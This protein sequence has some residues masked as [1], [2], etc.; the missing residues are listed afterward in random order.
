M[1]Y[2]DLI[3]IGVAGAWPNYCLISDCLISSSCFGLFI[4]CNCKSG[5]LFRLCDASPRIAT[6]GK[7][8]GRNF[9]LMA[10]LLD[11]F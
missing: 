7:K 3:D 5:L 11:Q 9:D 8:R 2:C 10:N 6:I 1:D 4:N